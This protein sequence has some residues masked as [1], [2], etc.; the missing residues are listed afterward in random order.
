MGLQR[1]ASIYLLG[2]SEFEQ[3]LISNKKN[4]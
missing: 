1:N 2:F 3:T 4:S